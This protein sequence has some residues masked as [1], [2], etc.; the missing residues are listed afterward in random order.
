LS[1]N[2]RYQFEDEISLH[3]LRNSYSLTDNLFV[4]MNLYM[5]KTANAELSSRIDQTSLLLGMEYS[6]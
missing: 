6:F 4:N 5:L 3:L 2:F 1:Y